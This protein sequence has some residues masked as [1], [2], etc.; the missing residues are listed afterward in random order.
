MFSSIV[1]VAHHPPPPPHNTFRVFC[2]PQSIATEL[3]LPIIE[4]YE[5]VI[6]PHPDVLSLYPFRQLGNH[7]NAEGYRLVAEAIADRL[8]ADGVFR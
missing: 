3:K 4:L 7:Y 6:F 1:T 2:C 5:E 8:K